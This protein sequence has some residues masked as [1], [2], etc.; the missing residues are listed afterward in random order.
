M[1]QGA[2]G[3]AKRDDHATGERSTRER[4]C[5]PEQLRGE[6]DRY[7]TQCVAYVRSRLRPTFAPVHCDSCAITEHLS[8]SACSLVHSSVSMVKINNQH[9]Q[10]RRAL[11]VPRGQLCTPS[12]T[13]VGYDGTIGG[14]RSTG[15]DR[16]HN[17]RA[18]QYRRG[19]PSQSIPYAHR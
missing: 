5:R 15:A 10:A 14:P 3:R 6:R 16:R 18:A 9:T 11:C 1:P 12:H 7:A 8:S 13:A 4:C 2:G 19:P 17:R